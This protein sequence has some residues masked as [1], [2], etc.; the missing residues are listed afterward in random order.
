MK[1]IFSI[2]ISF[3]FSF[4]YETD[5]NRSMGLRVKTFTWNTDWNKH[6]ISYDELLSGGPARDG[7]PPI[8]NPKFISPQE[9]KKWIKDKEPVI[10]VKIGQSVKAYPISVLMWHEIVNDTLEDKKIS[11]TFCPLCNSA[12][13]FDRVLDGKEYDFGTSGLLRNSDLVMYDRQTESL[14]QQFTGE[15]IVGEMVDKQLK[16]I[17]SSL[18]SFKDVYTNYPNALILSKET[19][20]K[21]EYGKNPYSGYDDINQTPFLFDKKSD[22]RLRP[23][24]KVLTLSLNGI[25]KAYTYDALKKVNIY[26]DRDL[27][28]ILFYK[29]GT[30]AALD[31]SE[32]KYSKDDGSYTVYSNFL[33]GEKLDFNYINGNFVDKNTKS[34]WNIFGQAIEGK[35]KGKELKPIIH[36]DHFWFSWAV[37][38]PKTLVYK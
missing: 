13:V 11:V 23:M 22:S 3:I 25:D 18:L 38:K 12:I 4:A 35:L 2:L 37:F 36:A 31:R 28:L 21:R 29:K 5:D 24:Q 32:I 6:S 16:F 27:G 14:W 30:N 17:A 34:I 10:F 19:G 33:D 9:A 1:L 20:Y 7:I 15:G 8:D 26:N